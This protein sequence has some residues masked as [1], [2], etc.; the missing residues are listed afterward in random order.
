MRPKLRLAAITAALTVLVASPTGANAA[1]ATPRLDHAVRIVQR[2]A[3]HHSGTRSKRV[4]WAT[5][6]YVN[7]TIDELR[8]EHEALDLH[9]PLP[10]TVEEA[11]GRRAGACGNMVAVALAIA[12]RLHVPARPVQ[13][14]YTMTNGQRGSHTMAE[15]YIHG[16]WRLFDILSNT[17]YRSRV[18][19]RL[20][21]LTQ[22]KKM[23]LARALRRAEHRYDT[24]YN[25]HGPD[26]YFRYL[27]D[28]GAQV[29]INDHGVLTWPSHISVENIPNYI[30]RPATFGTRH[31]NLSA[32]FTGLTAS[33]VTVHLTSGCSAGRIVARSGIRSS[34]PVGSSTTTVTL[35]VSGPN[36]VLSIESG[37]C[38]AILQGI[39]G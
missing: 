22:L 35:P 15:F 33:Q 18:T 4:A 34:A 24:G 20:L 30:G 11:L 25:Q 5:F 13:V 32:R 1:S 14:Y 10:S 37:G 3:Q 26:V 23:P 7:H 21:S 17:V 39:D 8:A 27:T 9:I 19:H 28:P 29:T 16:G 6:R 2:D 12:D 31:A 36:V 38:Y